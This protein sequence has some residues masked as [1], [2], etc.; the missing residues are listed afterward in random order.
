M[1][2]SY[3][4]YFKQTTYSQEGFTLLELLIVILIL[5]ILSAVALPSL[6]AQVDKAR[7]A[8]AKL[9]MGT[10]AR[11]LKA[12][13]LEQGHFPPDVYPNISPS[14]ISDFPQTSDGIIPFNSRYD[15]E[16]WDVN[17]NECYIQITFFGKNNSRDS[18]IETQVHSQP[19]IYESNAGD[20]LL[21]VVGTYNNSCQ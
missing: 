1:S 12:Y 17:G 16:S 18:P 20:D 21:Y 4:T 7:Y 9:Q 15:Y 10:V 5:G 2:Y 14:G 6:L 11:K 13:Y 3:T 8:E 19:G